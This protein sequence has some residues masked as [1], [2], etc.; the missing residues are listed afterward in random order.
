MTEKDALMDHKF[1]TESESSECY[2][3]DDRSLIASTVGINESTGGGSG[4]SSRD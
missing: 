1:T 2:S 4:S 3:N